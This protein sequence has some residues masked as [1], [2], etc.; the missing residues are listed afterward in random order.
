MP[1]FAH[2]KPLALFIFLA[3]LVG[4]AYFVRGH[5]RIDLLVDRIRTLGPWGPV[6]YIL[7]YLIAPAL[8]IPGSPITIA[9]G[10]LFGPVWGTLYT[11]V[12]ATGG[13][14]FAFFIARYLGA[15]W[16][17]G[18]T[19]GTLRRLKEGV[20]EEG[21]RFVAFTR[22]VPIFPFNLINYAF[23]LTRVKFSHYAVAS[24]FCMLPATAAFSL[25]G[26]AGREAAAGSEGLIVKIG[27]ALGLLIFVSLI[28][29]FLKARRERGSRIPR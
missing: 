19:T 18:R 23:G 2:K 20:E 6:A 12:G 29:R 27:A 5:I 22:L 9:G 4:L 16:V 7:L 28:P 21:W 15:D 24:F 8:F 11:S 13:A 10:A 17:E 25:I 1:P 3:G 26:Y 14:S